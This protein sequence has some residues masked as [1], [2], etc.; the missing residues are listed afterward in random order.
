M[1]DQFKKHMTGLATLTAP[2]PRENNP[3]ARAVRGVL[4]AQRLTTMDWP[5]PACLG[6]SDAPSGRPALDVCDHAARPIER[7]DIPA[8]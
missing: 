8:G 2:Y 4:H 7:R 6:G 5:G 1:R 3:L